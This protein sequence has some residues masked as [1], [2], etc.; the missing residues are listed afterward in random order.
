MRSMA[1]VLFTLLVACG[2]S[3]HTSNDLSVLDAHEGGG[4]L[5]NRD[6]SSM[7]GHGQVDSGSDLPPPSLQIITPNTPDVSPG[8]DTNYC[9]FFKTQNTTDLAIRRWTSHMAEGVH[10]MTLFL[11]QNDLKSP[12]TMTQNSCGFT[13]SASPLWTYSAQTSDAEFVLPPDDGDGIQLPR[14]SRVYNRALFKCTWSTRP[15]T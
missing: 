8:V 2:P 3:A 7:D 1:F 9:Y 14:K 4:D 10:D 15:P 12:G 13:F 11:T 6:S 5:S